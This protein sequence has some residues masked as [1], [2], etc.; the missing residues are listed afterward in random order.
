VYTGRALTREET[1]RLGSYTAAVVLKVEAGAE[2][3]L[4]EIRGFTKTLKDGLRGPVLKTSPSLAHAR[5]EGR[6]ILVVDDDMRTVY[7][8]SAQLRAKGAEVLVADTG[9]AALRVLSERS[10]VDSVLLD[11]MM[12]EMNGYETL[13]YIRQDARL[14]NLPVVV[15][16]AKAMK[17]EEEKCLEAGATDYLPKPIDI[18]RLLTLLQSYPFAHQSKPTQASYG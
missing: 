10:E 3:V 16:T 14:A 12:P 6:T 11:L 7:A 8:L 17:N 13:A 18:E 15:L 1:R 5:L 2:R 4:D 9:A